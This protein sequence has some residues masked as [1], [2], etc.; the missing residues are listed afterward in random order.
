[1]CETHPLLVFFPFIAIVVL[2]FAIRHT[3]AEDRASVKSYRVIESATGVHLVHSAYR[4]GLARL[5]LALPFLLREGA[6]VQV[7]VQVDLPGEELQTYYLVYQRPANAAVAA[8]PQEPE[9][10]NVVA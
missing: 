5:G 4:A 9:L 3:V 6:R 2:F 8:V 10:V 1:M 7:T